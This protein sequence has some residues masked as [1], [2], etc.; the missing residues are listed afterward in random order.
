MHR[1]VLIVEVD[2]PTDL[3]PADLVA[4]ADVLREAATELAPEGTT[5]ASVEL[6]VVDPP[7]SSDQSTAAASGAS[8]PVVDA[9]GA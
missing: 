4:M 2:E 5:R 9:T 8:P 6:G 3:S 7:P 1:V